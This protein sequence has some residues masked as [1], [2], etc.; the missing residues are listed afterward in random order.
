MGKD[1]N[2]YEEIDRLIKRREQLDHILN[3]RPLKPCEQKERCEL[4]KTLEHLKK[5]DDEAL[6]IE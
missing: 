2:M 1:N 5:E 6:G 4:E 3:K